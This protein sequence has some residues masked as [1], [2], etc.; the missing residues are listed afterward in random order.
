M[1]VS[2]LS[3]LDIF[4]GAFLT[5][6]VTCNNRQLTTSML[7]DLRSRFEFILQSDSPIFNPLPAV[8]CLLDVTL[9][10][11]MLSLELT[12]LLSAAKIYIVSLLR[13][14]QSTSISANQSSN[15]ILNYEKAQPAGLRRF[16]FSSAKMQSSS[17]T[18][19]ASNISDT[20]LDQL[21][22][23][24]IGLRSSNA[25]FAVNALD[26]WSLHRDIYDKLAPT[27]E[28]LLSAPAPQAYV[29]LCGM[30]TTG[31]RNRMRKSLEMRVFLKLNKKLIHE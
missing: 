2:L 20:C 27:A 1:Y 9:A 30:L 22:R 24:V 26:Y 23:Y 16:A 15:S 5:L 28:D 8:A 17:T 18:V 21:N 29:S 25:N 31:H 4:F 6:N 7:R 19:S 13:E 14:E 12:P 11:I 10:P 3:D